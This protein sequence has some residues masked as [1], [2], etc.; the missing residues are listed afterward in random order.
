MLSILAL[1]SYI[2]GKTNKALKIQ[3]EVLINIQNDIK[4]FRINQIRFLISKNL[5]FYNNFQKTYSDVTTKLS[6]LENRNLA[7]QIETD[8]KEYKGA[9]DEVVKNYKVIGLTP[10]TGLYGKL[11][12]SVH[13]MEDLINKLYIGDVKAEM[14][15]L[16]RHE[17]DFMLRNDLKYLKKFDAEVVK[18][19]DAVEE[20][21]LDITTVKTINTN[22]AKYI[23]DFHS[24]VEY[25]QKIGL[26]LSSGLIGEMKNS[27]EKLNKLLHT[28]IEKETSNI[29][30]RID[31]AY[32]TQLV[33]IFLFIIIIFVVA[34]YI[35]KIITDRIEKMV[36]STKEIA[37]PDANL[38]SRLQV[39]Q[40]ELGSANNN[41]NLFLDR[42]GD[43][44]K[45]AKTSVDESSKVSSSISNLSKN[46]S[47]NLDKNRKSIESISDKISYTQGLLN[48]NVESSLNSKN[49][50]NKLNN[51]VN[52]ISLQIDDF[53][54]NLNSTV[55]TEYEMRNEL[56]RLSSETNSVKNVLNIIKD[57]ADQTNLLALNAAIEAARAGE[58]GRG[59]AVV[60][61]EVRKLA[62][63]TQKSLVEIETTINIIVQ[64]IND[65]TVKIS[66]NSEE[67]EELSSKSNEISNSMKELNSDFE[68]LDRDFEKVIEDVTVTNKELGHINES[69]KSILKQTNMN[70]DNSKNIVTDVTSL[71]DKLSSLDAELD[72]FKF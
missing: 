46:S 21:G 23:K 17:K 56:D 43:I 70:Y 53:V 64:S 51:I 31:G 9:F 41:I 52:G 30:D 7:N 34:M 18:F 35:V 58:H 32:N 40:D 63:R 57:I 6:K 11:R 68:T 20:E 60:A 5:N 19:N 71:N 48:S 24:L 1:L 45:M 28:Q 55:N 69:S 13:N 33:L 66:K 26:T 3:Q 39:G 38:S 59:F 22:L 54:E 27:F 50:I 37:R 12:A 49:S 2:N 67:V 61:D 4:E 14:L 62:E 72:K 10:K 8:I 15:M 65:I 29:K 16:R 36:E 47:A 42:M 25:Q 44:V